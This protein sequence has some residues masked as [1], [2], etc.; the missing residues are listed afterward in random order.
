[1]KILDPIKNMLKIVY[2]MYFPFKRDYKIPSI[3]S[4]TVTVHYLM[5]SVPVTC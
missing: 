5:N 2:M 4:G 3:G 1:M